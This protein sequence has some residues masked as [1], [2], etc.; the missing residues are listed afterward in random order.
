MRRGRRGVQAFGVAEPLL[1]REQVV[2]LALGR[3]EPLDLAEPEP[4]GVGLHGAFARPGDDL[5]KLAARLLVPPI[6]ALVLRQR[7]GKLGARVAV[8]RLP[9][10]HG[11]QQLPLV[12]LAV[13]GDQVIGQI[14]KQ[15]D[16]HRPAAGERA[17]A[18]L[19]RHRTADDQRAALVEF[20]ARLL[21]LAG[22]VTLRVGAEPAFDGRAIRAWPDSPV[23][24]VNP[25]ESSST[26]S[27][28]T[29]SPVMCTSSSMVAPALPLVR[30]LARAR[31]GGARRSR[32]APSAPPARHG[33]AE[34]LHEPVGESR[35]SRL[36]WQP[37]ADDGVR[38]AAHLD[39]RSWV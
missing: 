12:R 17:G 20:A 1:F 6:D 27:S 26:A 24:T 10:P 21:D 15:A 22:D 8:E 33:Q 19:H 35:A 3:R 31:P 38:A 32:V 18:S 39:P 16:G 36:T 7:H 13:Y 11:P 37:G 4:K 5:F 23:T 34:L 29:P 25:V 9:L 28:M 2:V 30:R 14:G